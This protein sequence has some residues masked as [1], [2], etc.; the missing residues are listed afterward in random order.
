M[1]KHIE[2]EPVTDERIQ[3]VVVTINGPVFAELLRT[4][5]ETRSFLSSKYLIT[6]SAS[7][8]FPETNAIGKDAAV[9]F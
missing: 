8:V 6:A 9:V 1:R 7:K 2:A 3:G 4:K 5:H